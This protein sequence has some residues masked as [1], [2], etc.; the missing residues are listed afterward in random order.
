MCYTG[1]GLLINEKHSVRHSLSIC[2][3]TKII[4]MNDS[5]EKHLCN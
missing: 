3:F 5:E 2:N 4:K 1:L